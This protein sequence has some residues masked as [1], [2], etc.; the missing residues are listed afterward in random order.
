[1]GR[2]GCVVRTKPKYLSRITTDLSGAGSRLVDRRGIRNSD[3]LASPLG[4]KEATALSKKM[5]RL[6][7]LYVDS[8]WGDDVLRNRVQ[9]MGGRKS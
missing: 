5:H 6:M 8:F 4:A 7:L 1:M 2:K 3:P 9:T